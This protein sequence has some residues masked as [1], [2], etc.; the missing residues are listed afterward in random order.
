MTYQALGAEVIQAIQTRLAAAPP[1][2]P[3]AEGS[4]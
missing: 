1:A 3:P 4:R 2:A